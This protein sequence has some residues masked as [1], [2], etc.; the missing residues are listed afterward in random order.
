[1][2]YLIKNA[3]IIPMSTTVILEE[4]DMHIVDDK[5]VKV[6]KN[7]SIE[8]AEIIDAT[9][10]FVIPGLYDMHYHISDD[11][12]MWND[13]KKTAAW[14]ITTIRNMWGN[15]E[16]LEVKKQIQSNAFFAPRILTTGPIIDG[17]PPVWEGSTLLETKDD[18]TQII[19]EHINKGYDYIKVYNNI[20]KEMYILLLQ[21]ARK[22]NLKVVGHLP[23]A[24]SN[25]LAM[26]CG[27][28]SFEHAKAIKSNSIERAAKEG[29]WYVPTM[30]TE[31]V[32]HRIQNN[33][34]QA[35]TFLEESYSH[36]SNKRI[37]EWKE[38]IAFFRNYDFKHER[39]LGE[40]KADILR[41]HKLGGRLL[42]GT[43]SPMPLCPYGLALHE[44]LNILNEIGLTPF[45]ALQTATINAA[46]SL[47][48]EN[49]SGTIEPN[50]EASLVFLEK[51]PLSN[52]HNTKTIK[53]VMVRG[54]YYSDQEL[55]QK[56]REIDDFN[57][58]QDDL[59]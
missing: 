19:E 53:A 4:Y 27:Q 3:T 58:T 28:Y 40:F 55:T 48:I 8:N 56:W 47:G 9:G 34:I 52:I 14:G 41:Y 36:I 45:E 54:V 35:D 30:I 59:R 33:A 2:T 22:V 18:V 38:S 25:E 42:A 5:I 43:D 44:E 15:D 21:E 6:A 20:P 11:D 16:I 31:E 37:N 49:E 1:M 23:V 29:F 7:L 17:N 51:N 24:V 26:D 32:V 39:N 50:K 13:L 12:S 46:Y 10:L 57:Q